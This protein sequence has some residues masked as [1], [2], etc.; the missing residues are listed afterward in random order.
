MA[1]GNVEWRTA[2]EEASKEARAQDKLVLVDLF[3]PG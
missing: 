2:I 3:N 1:T